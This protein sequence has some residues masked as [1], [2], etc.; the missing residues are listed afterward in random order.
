MLSLHAS[1]FCLGQDY[2]VKAEGVMA[3]LSVQAASHWV[4]F[5]W[6][7]IFLLAGKFSQTTMCFSALT[8]LVAHLS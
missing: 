1:N 4:A 7:K 6:I 2:Q 3:V 5:H 8:L